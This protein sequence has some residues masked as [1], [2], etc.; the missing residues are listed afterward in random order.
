[1]G[2]QL[3]DQFKPGDNSLHG[4]PLPYDGWVEQLGCAPS[5]AQA[6]LPFPQFC[7]RLQAT[8]ENAGQSTYHSF[9]FKFQKEFSAGTY[10]LA[11]YTLSK[12]LTNSGTAQVRP[13]IN[14][15]FS[16]FERQRNKSLAP[17]DVPHN[18]TV[19]WVYQLPFGTGHRFL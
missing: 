18:F 10:I 8:N 1:M 16:P 4:V 15:V 12:M 2:P 5:V 11:S 7:D 13:P 14:H 9:Q 6:L 17:D 19:A 3:R